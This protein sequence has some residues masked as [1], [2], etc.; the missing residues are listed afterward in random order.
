MVSTSI[1]KKQMLHLVQAVIMSDMANENKVELVTILMAKSEP[2]VEPKPEA[3]KPVKAV[4]KPEPK[5]EAK[6]ELKPE[7]EVKAPTT[8]IKR[9]RK[10]V[11]PP[12]SPKVIVDDMAKKQ[13]VVDAKKNTPKLT[14]SIGLNLKEQPKVQPLGGKVLEAIKGI[15]KQ[16]KNLPFDIEQMASL[17]AG[18]A[19]KAQL[20][21]TFE[22]LNTSENKLYAL[23]QVDGAVWQNKVKMSW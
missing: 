9:E 4:T 19:T 2:K 21:S 10:V 14:K 18:H 13:A 20:I 11:T 3:K 12:V 17:L 16:M 8:T 15:L 5:P 1:D 7:P 22:Y 6:P 23:Q